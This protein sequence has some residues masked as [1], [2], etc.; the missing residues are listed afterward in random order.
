MEGDGAVSLEPYR[1]TAYFNPLPPHGGRPTLPARK[2]SPVHFNPLPPHGGRPFLLE[3]VQKPDHF[4]PLPPH[5]GRQFILMG[6]QMILIFQSTPSA[7]RETFNNCTYSTSTLVFQSTPSAWRE[8]CIQWLFRNGFRY[9]NPLPP[10]GG[11]PKDGEYRRIYKIISIHSLR[12]E[13]DPLQIA[14]GARPERFQSTPSAWRETQQLGFPVVS[15]AISIH[16]LRMEGDRRQAAAGIRQ[17]D[18]NPLPPHG[19]RRKDFSERIWNN[20][21]FQSTPSAWRETGTEACSR[22]RQPDFNPLP[23]HGGRLPK[24]RFCSWKW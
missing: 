14:D 3:T 2:K 22:T 21:T 11:R 7:W 6:I 15:K 20:R 19:G 23:P 10:H 24:A 13:G 9:F 8:T 17:A 1:R 18:F 5:G 12:M 4:N 16:S